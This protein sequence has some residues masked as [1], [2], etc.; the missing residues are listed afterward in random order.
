MIA[1]RLS[2]R[3]ITKTA[4]LQLSLLQHSSHSHHHHYHTQNEAFN[5]LGLINGQFNYA[6]MHLL[7]GTTVVVQTILAYPPV[8]VNFQVFVEHPPAPGADVV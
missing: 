5:L 1:Q 4:K 8:A 2:V 6:A 3:G 7:P